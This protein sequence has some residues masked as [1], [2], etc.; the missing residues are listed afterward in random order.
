MVEILTNKGKSFD[1]KMVYEYF[2]KRDEH[3]AN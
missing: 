2:W 1:I 3:H